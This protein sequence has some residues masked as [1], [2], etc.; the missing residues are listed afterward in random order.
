MAGDIISFVLR[1]TLVVTLCSY[2]WRFVKPNTQLMRVLR[3]AL[4]VLTLLGIL[5]VLRVTGTN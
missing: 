5:V 3:A 2:V 1:I 4:L